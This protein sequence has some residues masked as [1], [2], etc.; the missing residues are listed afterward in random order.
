[1]NRIEV[2]DR[3]VYNPN[4]SNLEPNT[5]RP[6]N[7]GI[8]ININD[9]VHVRFN[10]GEIR[11]ILPNA[12]THYSQS[13]KARHKTHKNKFKIVLDNIP[14]AREG[15][16]ARKVWNTHINLPFV[17]GPGKNFAKSWPEVVAPNRASSRRLTQLRNKI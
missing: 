6:R 15:M 9:Y 7:V 13:N 2:G 14:R 1:M 12:L 11:R 4:L 5:E 16:E 17:S 3:V 10:N 8:V